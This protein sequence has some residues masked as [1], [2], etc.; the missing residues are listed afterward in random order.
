EILC[1]LYAEVL[2]L[3]VVG[4]DDDF[5]A[6]GGHSLF[7][8]QLVSRIRTTLGVEIGIQ[9]LFETAVVADIARRVV[10]AAPSER[11]PLAPRERP[12]AIPLSFAQQ[13]LWFLHRMD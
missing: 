13:R 10:A 12:A 3:P 5:F 11:P 8:T 2:N 6:L 7:A 9:A 1:A 4:A